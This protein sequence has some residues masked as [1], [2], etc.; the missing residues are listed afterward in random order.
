MISP[1]MVKEMINKQMAEK[2]AGYKGVASQPTIEQP[3][4]PK[5]AEPVVKALDEVDCIRLE[6]L[7]LKQEL[8]RTVQKVEN[9]RRDNIQKAL[10]EAQMDLQ[11]FLVEKYEVDTSKNKLV[12]NGQARTLTITPNE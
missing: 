11:T 7:V 6:N 12:I 2:L 3:E 9:G 5:P 4:P 1:E 8:E 10:N